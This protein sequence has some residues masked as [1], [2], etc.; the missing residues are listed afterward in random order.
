MSVETCLEIL[1]ANDLRAV[2]NIILIH[3]SD[4][5]SDA[6]VFKQRI[7]DTTLKNVTIAIAGLTIENFNIH[8]F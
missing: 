8:P 4:K 1:Q 2:N 6:K 3:L 7:E 5:N